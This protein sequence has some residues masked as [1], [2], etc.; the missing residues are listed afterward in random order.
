[1][2]QIE[3]NNGMKIPQMGLGTYNMTKDLLVQSVSNALLMGYRLFDTAPDYYNDIS[4]GIALRTNTKYSRDEY[5]ISSKVDYMNTNF[6]LYEQFEGILNRMKVEY[7]DIYLL[8]WPYPDKFIQFWTMMEKIYEQKLVKCIGVCN[9]TSKHLIKLENSTNI[10]PA[11]NQI[12][13]HPLFTQ[14]ETVAYCM[15]KDIAI[16]SYSP[17]A[18]MNEKLIKH[19]TLLRLAE[20]YGKTV[21]Q[22]IVRWNIQHNYSVIPKASSVKH[23]MENCTIWDF[24]LTQ[25]DM[26]QIDSINENY[27]VR[28]DPDDMSIYSFQ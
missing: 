8:H 14:E 12:E 21:S 22:I 23:I 13:L 4:L 6:N 16:M 26:T 27:R 11:I 19:P 5:F 2:N 24:T 7:L 3:L 20:Q 1:M 25:N 28:L 15:K 18:R 17:L 9:F 10:P